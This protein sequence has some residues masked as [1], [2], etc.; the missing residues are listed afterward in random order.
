MTGTAARLYFGMARV[1]RPY[2][3]PFSAVVWGICNL[4][5]AGFSELFLAADEFVWA[6]RFPLT[7]TVFAALIVLTV[8][9]ALGRAAFVRPSG[10]PHWRQA[11]L[12][13][14]GEPPPGNRLAWPAPDALAPRVA[15]PVARALTQKRRPVP[16]DLGTGPNSLVVVP[17][18]GFIGAV[19]SSVLVGATTLVSDGPWTNAVVTFIWLSWGAVVWGSIT[20]AIALKTRRL[21]E[22]A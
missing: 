22:D 13:E 20:I 5:L 6:S 19:L 9:Y 7:K 17:M 14:P 12:P 16:R 10:A 15:T 21:N 2:W 1:R 11:Q 4:F 3:L 18:V 8:L